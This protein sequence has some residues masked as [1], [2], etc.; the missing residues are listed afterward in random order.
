MIVCFVP[1]SFYYTAYIKKIKPEK[2]KRK[3]KKMVSS[4]KS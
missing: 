3:N 4:N 2:E 1:Y